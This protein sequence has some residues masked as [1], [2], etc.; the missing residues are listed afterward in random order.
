MTDLNVKKKYYL[1]FVLQASEVG[2]RNETW[3]N[4]PASDLHRFI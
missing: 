1:N 2:H 3:K 4:T